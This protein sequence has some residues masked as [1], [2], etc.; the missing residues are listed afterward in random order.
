MDLLA[1]GPALLGVVIGAVLSSVAGAVV[2]RSQWQRTMAIR[3]DER[4]L[5]TYIE[6]MN[7]VKELAT[8]SLRIVASKGVLLGKSPESVIPLHKDEGYSML[9]QTEQRRSAKA[10][11]IL[12]LGDTATIA[13]MTALTE[14]LWRLVSFART[15]NTDIDVWH[16][17]YAAYHNARLDFYKSARSSMGVPSAKIPPG[18]YWSSDRASALSADE[19]NSPF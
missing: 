16:D 11:A 13:S 7:E 4:R 1:Q 2:A 6:Y 9:A 15:D 14:T 17:A 10:E 12:L 18:T 8:T 3:W 5:S 19:T